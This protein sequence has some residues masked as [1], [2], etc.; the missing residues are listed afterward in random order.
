MIYAPD[1][2]WSI[3]INHVTWIGRTPG[4]HLGVSRKL[5]NLPMISKDAQSNHHLPESQARKAAAS[6]GCVD[7][8]L[9][10]LLSLEH[11]LFQPKATRKCCRN[12]RRR[13]GPILTHSLYHA[14]PTLGVGGP[15]GFQQLL[16][17]LPQLSPNDLIMTSTGCVCQK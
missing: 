8:S 16:G 7:P 15:P 13:Q 2:S 17:M 1:Q 11:L 9:R 6:W 12:W 4:I 10:S 14:M 5:V 3:L